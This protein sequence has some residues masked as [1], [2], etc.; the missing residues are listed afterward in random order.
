[1]ETQC[2]AARRGDSPLLP[3]RLDPAAHASTP[4]AESA[5]GIIARAASRLERSPFPAHAE[6]MTMML[7]ALRGGFRWP[8]QPIISNLWLFGPWPPPV[9]KERRPPAALTP[10]SALARTCAASCA[11]G[12]REA[13]TSSRHLAPHRRPPQAAQA[14]LRRQAAHRDARAHHHRAHG[15]PRGR[16]AGVA[17]A[18][19]A[20]ATG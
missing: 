9:A 6:C 1:M 14:R 8:L 20:Q 4:P 13:V 19:R 17:R 18:V 12:G 15:L 11:C 10:A 7:G 5:I 2:V 16:P 3:P